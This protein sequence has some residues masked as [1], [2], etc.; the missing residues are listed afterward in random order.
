[1]LDAPEWFAEYLAK[2]APAGDNGA[3]K[4]DPM[5]PLDKCAA[6]LAALDP[7]DYRDQQAWLDLAMSYYYITGGQG[8]DDFREW[9]DR[10]TCY[11]GNTDNIESR[12]KSFGNRKAAHRPSQE[13]DGR[14]TQIHRPHRIRRKPGRQSDVAY[15]HSCRC[16]N[17][18]RSS[19][20]IQTTVRP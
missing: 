6:M 9:C 4:R 14:Q 5:Y 3:P 1:M 17:E 10:D 11:S 19:V 16:A 13:Q 20:T 7:V 12:W 2:R 8:L 15:P 18:P